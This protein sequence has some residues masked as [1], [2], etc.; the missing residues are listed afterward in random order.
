MFCEV[1]LRVWQSFRGAIVG[2]GGDGGN[3]GV[4]GNDI[5]GRP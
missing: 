5:S 3:V 1:V 4:S 2:I